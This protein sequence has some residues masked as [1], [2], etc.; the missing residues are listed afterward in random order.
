MKE[1][2][3]WKWILTALAIAVIAL[4]VFLIARPGVSAG[5]LCGLIGAVLLLAGVVRI[6]CYFRRGISV[7]W[8]WYELPLGV[9]DA[10]LGAYFLSRPVNVMLV[11]PVVAGIAIV[12]DSLFQ[13][14]TALELKRQG[15]LRWRGILAFSVICILFALLLIANPFGGTVALMIYLGISLVIDGV[16]S[17]VFVHQVAKHIRERAPLEADYTVEEP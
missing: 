9:L 4:G 16:Q 15:S 13:L 6:L 10:L 11:M 1:L 8:H 12:V 3:R 7:L 2:K 14:Q 17:L 5:V